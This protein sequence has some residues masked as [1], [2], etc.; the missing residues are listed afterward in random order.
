MPLPA[1][2]FDDVAG[3]R[4]LAVGALGLVE[5]EVAP[6]A[7]GVASV[8][9]ERACLKGVLRHRAGRRRAL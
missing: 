3:H 1:E 8:Q 7:V 9:H 4:L 2:C 5:T 6:F